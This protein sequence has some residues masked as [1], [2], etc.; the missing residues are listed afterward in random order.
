MSG[1][2]P[3]AR[4]FLKRELISYKNKGK[5][6]FFSSHILSDMDEICDNIA[7]L[8]KSKI[9]YIGTPLGLK[10]KH[11]KDNYIPQEIFKSGRSCRSYRR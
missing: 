2:D 7:V 9:R 1:L 10:K 5:T 4:I 8:H 11:D 3:Q 6:I